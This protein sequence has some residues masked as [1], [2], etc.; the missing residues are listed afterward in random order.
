MADNRS[1]CKYE[2][3][4]FKYSA[5]GCDKNPVRTN[6]KR[7][8]DDDKLH[9]QITQDKVLEQNERIRSLEK[10][11]HRSVILRV[12]ILKLN[13]NDVFFTK[14]LYSDLFGY[15]LCMEVCPN[16]LQSG[17]NQL[18]FLSELLFSEP[19]YISL[20]FYLMKGEHDESLTWAFTGTVTVEL[21]NQL[22]D[23]NHHKEKIIFS[24]EDEPSHRVELDRAATASS[25]SRFI[26]YDR[27][28]YQPDKNCQNLNNDTLIF[29]VLVQAS[30]DKPWQQPRLYQR[31][32][33]ET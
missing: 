29:R 17:N 18:S 24:A 25:V 4:T 7:H 1:T 28:G 5:L 11:S 13:T 30:N 9:V 6:L 8:E 20:H 16:G 12:T 26:S 27:L 10:V 14:P 19:H 22:E 3:I 21:L 23:K 2:P 32:L 33:T 15:K 31:L